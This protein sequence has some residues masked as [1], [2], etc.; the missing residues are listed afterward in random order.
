MEGLCTNCGRLRTLV[1]D[2]W[3]DEWV[4][5]QC[6]KGEGEVPGTADTSGDE[7]E[8]EEIPKNIHRSH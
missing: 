8:P 7:S 6:L 3:G 4:C 5:V 2:Q 1:Y